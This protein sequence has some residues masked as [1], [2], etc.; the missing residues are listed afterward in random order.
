MEE[1]PY[2]HGK[3]PDANRRRGLK[4]A[5][6]VLAAAAAGLAI[7]TLLEHGQVGQ[8]DKPIRARVEEV[9][10]NCRAETNWR[11]LPESTNWQLLAELLRVDR[12]RAQ[13]SEMALVICDE[14]VQ[15]S[16]ILNAPINVA[17]HEGPCLPLDLMKDDKNP[18]DLH[19]EIF[20]VCA[21]QEDAV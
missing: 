13:S 20:A 10:P 16:D 3:A 9:Q 5:A 11:R 8:D 21:R 19:K 12:P 4:R 14:G 2:H 17:G 1:F 7:G 18:F 6:P 15:A